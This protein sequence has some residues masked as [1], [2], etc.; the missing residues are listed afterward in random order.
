MKPAKIT[1][2]GVNGSLLNYCS[3]IRSIQILR[4]NVGRYTLSFLTNCPL[5]ESK[6]IY[7]IVTV[8]CQSPP[9]TATVVNVLSP[10]AVYQSKNHEEFV[11]KVNFQIE[12]QNIA[13]TLPSILLT[14][15][16][17]NLI[18]FVDRP[19]VMV[20]YELTHLE[21]GNDEY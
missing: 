1:F 20:D 8:N 4:T 2:A 15:L 10:T 17:F 5:D 7:P 18:T 13:V 21:K 11:Y 9:G 14:L 3:D 6:Q 19:V 12:V 16:G